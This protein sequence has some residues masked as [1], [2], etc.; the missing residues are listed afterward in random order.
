MLPL[1]L[2][3]DIALVVEL[4]VVLEAELDIADAWLLV[5]LDIVLGVAVEAP[6]VVDMVGVPD[7]EVTEATVLSELMTKYAL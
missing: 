3:V 5:M 7:R 6:V 4:A 1:V 2:I